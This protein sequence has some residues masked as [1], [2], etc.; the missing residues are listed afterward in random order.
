MSFGSEELSQDGVKRINSANENS[1]DNNLLQPDDTILNQ[2]SSTTSNWWTNFN[3]KMGEI[4]WYL[5]E[6]EGVRVIN[7]LN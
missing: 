7:E 5:Q 2:S 3:E 1:P 6:L 4:W